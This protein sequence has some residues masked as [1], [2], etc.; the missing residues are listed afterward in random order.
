[1]NP[2]N[3]TKMYVGI[4]V[5]QAQLAVAVRVGSQRAHALGDYANSAAGF[6]QLAS[7]L[8]AVCVQ[9]GATELHLVVEAT[10]GYEAALVAYAHQ[11]GWLV[12]R[13]NAYHVRRWASSQGRRGKSD[14]LDACVLADFGAINQ[15]AAQHAMDEAA[16]QLESLLRRRRDVEQLLRQESNR[17]KQYGQRPHV[18]SAVHES[19][20]R[21]LEALTQELAA[22]NQAIK[23]LTAAS[24]SLAQ[25]VRILLSMPGVGPKSVHYLL[26]L[27]YRFQAHTAGHGTAKQLTAYLGLDPQPYQSGSSVYRPASI[28]KMGDDYGRALF[29]MA[30]AGGVRGIIPSA[31]SSLCARGKPYKV[32]II[33]CTRKLLTWA[34]ALFHSQKPFDPSLHQI[35]S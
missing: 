1:M 6:G 23:E 20:Q 19:L 14:P 24:A 21:T 15:V 30:T 28:S 32:A 3:G 2:I 26:T 22:L 4:D 27:L 31:L 18:P 25:M 34:W 35:P 13:V 33:A 17:Q 9:A 29:F 5:S 12:S 8:A 11:A 7:A 10:G 16:A